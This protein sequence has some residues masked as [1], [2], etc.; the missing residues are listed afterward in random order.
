MTKVEIDALQDIV[1]TYEKEGA[2][3]VN[4]EHIRAIKQVIRD[5]QDPVWFFT[6]STKREEQ[7]CS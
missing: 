1:N 4:E 7:K 3:S 6:P 2:C 5:V